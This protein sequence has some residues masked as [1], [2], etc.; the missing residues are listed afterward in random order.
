MSIWIG[1][2]GLPQDEAH[3]LCLALKA[4]HFIAEDLGNGV[5]AVNTEDVAYVDYIFKRTCYSTAKVSCIR[6]DDSELAKVEANI[7]YLDRK[8]RQR[9]HQ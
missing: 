6:I 7:D 1:F 4:A 5:V 3:K 9:H 2:R 8:H